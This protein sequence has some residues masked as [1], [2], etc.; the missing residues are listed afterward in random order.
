MSRTQI[1]LYQIDAFTDEL[2]RGN[3]AAVCPLEAWLPDPLMQSIAAE[4]NLSETAFFVP[5]SDGAYELRWFTPACE[6]DLCGHATLASAVALFEELGYDDD[7][8]TF[9]SPRSGRLEV[10]RVGDKL[11]LDFPARRPEPVGPDPQLAVALGRA[12]VQLWRADRFLAVYESEADVRAL[13]PDFA[14]LADIR[15]TVVAT[16]P[17]DDDGID[18][19][20]RFF[21]PSKGVDE[22]PVTG[23]AHCVLTPYWADRLGKT[24]LRARQISTR[25]GELWC[26]DSG[27]RVQIAG[28]GAIYLTGSIRLPA[29]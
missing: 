19:V 12:P 8:I 26:R 17:A 25:G 29:L 13:T 15:D 23:S 4:N 27:D 11:E 9:H 28:R 5:R 24:E 16:A 20:S 14:A 18:F 7:R 3:P 10:A 6:I 21:A 1:P 2:F 22:D